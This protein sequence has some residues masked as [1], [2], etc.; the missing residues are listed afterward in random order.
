MFLV[1]IYSYLKYYIYIY[2]HTHTRVATCKF[3]TAEKSIFNTLTTKEQ[4]YRFQNGEYPMLIA[5]LYR[6]QEINNIFVRQQ[7]HG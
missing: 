4:I 5:D 6:K 3:L 1:S 2:T 7:T